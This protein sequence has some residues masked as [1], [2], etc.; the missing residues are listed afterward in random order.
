MPEPDAVATPPSER[1]RA[2]RSLRDE[3][4]KHYLETIHYIQHEEGRVR[5]S[6]LADWMAVSPATV[7]TTLRGLEASGWIR[8]AVDRSVALTPKGRR[9]AE[10]IVRSHRLL[11]RWLTD[12]LGLDWASADEEAQNLAPAFSKALADR[13]DEHLGRP[14]T[15]PHGNVIPGRDAP[16][17]ALV[18]LADL[19]PD[20]PAF[21]RRISEVAE[22]DAPD[23]LR[24]LHDSGVEIGTRVQVTGGRNTTGAISLRTG[25]RTIAFG[26]EVARSIWV[27]PA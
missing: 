10:E 4:V 20:T 17:G 3:T 1:A 19:E 6:R 25:R 23:L 14:T 2:V 18:S 9:A 22:H 8:V 16:Y 15:C 26:T 21:V 24:L 12:R 7:S 27:E 11:E 13:L 5:P